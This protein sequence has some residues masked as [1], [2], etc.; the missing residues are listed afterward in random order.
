MGEF[1]AEYA[2]RYPLPIGTPLAGGVVEETTYTAYKVATPT[3]TVFVPFT[4]VHPLKP[5]TPLVT[6]TGGV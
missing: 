5:A 2:E 1:P 3:G 4:K 6:M